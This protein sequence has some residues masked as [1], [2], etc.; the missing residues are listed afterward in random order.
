M[1]KTV[2]VLLLLWTQISVAQLS[3]FADVNFTKADNIAKNHKPK[4]KL[5][6]YKTTNFLTQN[7]QTDVEK[8]RA[9]YVWIAHNIANDFSLYSKNDRKRKRFQQDSIRLDEWNSRFKKLLFSKLL[10]RKKTICTGYA[11]LFKEMCKVA[12]LEAKIVHGFGRTAAVDF[13][14][15]T[16]PN[17]SWNMVKLNDKWYFIDTT[18][19]AGISY[20]NQKGFVF[21]F[22]DGYF[23]TNPAFFIYNHY[24]LFVEKTLLEKPPTFQEFTDKPM[25]YGAAYIYVDEILQPKK[26]YQEINKNDV[27]TFQYH[28][29]KV[30]DTSKLKLILTD[31]TDNQVDAKITL[32]KNVLRVTYQFEK[33]GFYDVHLYYKDDVLATYAIKILADGYQ[34]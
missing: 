23:L 3:D 14:E 16:E 30:M 5:D 18:W 9:I 33:T 2:V 8:A 26:L 25:V 17:H 27:V 15:L 28:L 12:N 19:A 7:L 6:I 21:E 24:P 32:D 34:N 29:K 31:R 10:K 13:S 20:P 11:M 4:G 22:N 1:R